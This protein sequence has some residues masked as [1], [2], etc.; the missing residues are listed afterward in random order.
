[1]TLWFLV[2]AIAMCHLANA[3]L[4]NIA[5]SHPR[6][7]GDPVRQEKLVDLKMI[8]NWIPAYAGMT[9]W[10]LVD[11]IA[12]CHLAIAWLL[13]LAP[14][15]PREGGDPVRQEKLVDLKMIF[16]W[17]LAYARMMLRLL[18]D[19]IAMCHLA[20]AWLSNLAPS[21]P[22]ENGDPVKQDSKPGFSAD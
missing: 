18:V 19:V 3:W 6:E 22:R 12:M 8:F 4:W 2:D 11:V 17:I 20:T 5:P 15:H 1:M 16:N 13:K 14:S 7:G 9:L 21:H 10:F